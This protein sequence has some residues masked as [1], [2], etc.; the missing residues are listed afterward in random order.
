MSLLIQSRKDSL[1]LSQ[2]QLLV[3]PVNLKTVSAN[4]ISILMNRILVDVFTLYLKTKTFYWYLSR[5]YCHH[6]YHLR[7]DEQAEQLFAMTYPIAGHIRQLGGATLPSKR[8]M[9]RTEQIIDNETESV[10]PVKMLTELRD[11]NKSMIKH[12][13]ETHAL[14]NA[15]HDIA[16]ASLIETWIDE[17]EERTRFLHEATCPDGHSIVLT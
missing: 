1:C 5:L 12:F 8:D 16:S 7:L 13:R 14:C 6:D 9:S 10:N 3:I 2:D 4:C 15:H 11:D 17:T